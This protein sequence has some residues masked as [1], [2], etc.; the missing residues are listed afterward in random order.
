MNKQ[1]GIKIIN[2][3]TKRKTTRKEFETNV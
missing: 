3:L 1:V 2:T